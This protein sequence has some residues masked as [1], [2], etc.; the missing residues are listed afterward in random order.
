MMKTGTCPKCGS[1]DVYSGAHITNKAGVEN[2][3]TIPLGGSNLL[4]HLMPL[5]N[6]VC[7][8]CGYVE[9]YISDPRDLQR[10]AESWQRADGTKKT[11]RKPTGHS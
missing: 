5:D 11:G 7:V 8:N 4:P 1:T 9:S 10:I 6:Y 3:N 2:T